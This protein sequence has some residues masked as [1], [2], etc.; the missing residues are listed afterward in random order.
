M[1]TGVTG[2]RKL[3]TLNAESHIQAIMTSNIFPRLVELL[4][5][6]CGVHIRHEVSWCLSIL[7]SENYAV[8]Q[9][10]LQKGI[11]PRL[12]QQLSD[13]CKVLCAQA[14]WMLGN[15][16]A[17]GC[18]CRDAVV[19]SGALPLLGNLLASA[20]DMEMVKNV[21]WTLAN[22]IRGSPKVSLEIVKDILP[23]I[24]HAICSYED[25]EL[26]IDT[27]W[28]LVSIIEDGIKEEH[29][30]LLRAPVIPRLVKL[31]S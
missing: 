21:Y 31:S 10:M 6:S 20:T 12:L 17:E 7:G 22:L 23:A 2:I 3:L 15:I 28:S 14:V 30:A 4:D 18:E 9:C 16:A 24:I 13:K 1:L 11:V 5:T 26:L 27:C 29:E 19:R 25:E 8:V